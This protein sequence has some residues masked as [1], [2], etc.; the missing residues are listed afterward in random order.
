MTCYK[1]YSVTVAETH[2]FLHTT[3][4][5]QT[6]IGANACKVTS[7][8]IKIASSSFLCKPHCQD[9]ITHLMY[10]HPCVV[11]AGKAIHKSPRM[12]QLMQRQ[13]DQVRFSRL[14]LLPQPNL[15]CDFA[16]MLFN[17]SVRVTIFQGLVFLCPYSAKT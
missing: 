7:T 3:V 13:V 14:I 6:M 15:R 1:I 4:T 16:R 9:Q 11:T 8:Y 10:M 12:E 2:V 5:K 17:E